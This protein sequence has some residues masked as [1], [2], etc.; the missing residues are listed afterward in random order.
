MRSS[1][2]LPQ[3]D[4]SGEENARRFSDK[5]DRHSK[6]VAVGKDFVFQPETTVLP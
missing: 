4:I 2:N 5:T 6:Y 3:P 1:S